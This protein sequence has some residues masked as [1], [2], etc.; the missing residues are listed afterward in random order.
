MPLDAGDDLTRAQPVFV[1]TT[2]PM[3]IGA[4][5]ALT[6]SG[7]VAI[8][9]GVPLIS[10]AAFA[11]D[12]LAVRACLSRAWAAAAAWGAIGV[13]LLLVAAMR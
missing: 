8:T 7:V 6:T 10:T 9:L 13:V 4:A 2:T 5:T 3:Q 11:V 12:V 1:R